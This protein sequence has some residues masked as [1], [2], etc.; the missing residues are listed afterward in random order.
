MGFLDPKPPQA[1]YTASALHGLVVQSTG[2]REEGQKLTMKRTPMGPEAPVRVASDS[3]ARAKVR[4]V[5]LCAPD[6][7]P[8]EYS[9]CVKMKPRSY[10]IYAMYLR[11]KLQSVIC[12]PFSANFNLSACL[13]VSKRDSSCFD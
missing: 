7:S 2:L 4:C 9:C 1:L 5:A 3:Q 8:S 6:T 12:S 13:H 10:Q 11:N